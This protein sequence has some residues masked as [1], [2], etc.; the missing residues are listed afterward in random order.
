MDLHD[1]GEF[2]LPR[3]RSAAGSE[4]GENSPD[5][6]RP[7]SMEAAWL[8]RPCGGWATGLSFVGAGSPWLWPMFDFTKCTTW[9][10]CQLTIQARSLHLVDIAR[11]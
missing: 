4:G 8:D 9:G 3:Q 7:S 2:R 6:A 11:R 5:Y 10:G 1:C